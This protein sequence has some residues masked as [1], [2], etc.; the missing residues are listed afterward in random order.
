LGVDALLGEQS[1]LHEGLDAI[2]LLDDMV[3]MGEILGQDGYG[4]HHA[5][6]IPG[7]QQVEA[8]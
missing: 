5:L 4:I 8:P 6:I 7:K 2:L 3:R 1:R